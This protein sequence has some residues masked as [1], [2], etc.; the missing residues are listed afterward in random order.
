MSARL[1]KSTKLINRFLYTRFPIIEEK[2]HD[3]DVDVDVEQR[4]DRLIDY[5]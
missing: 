4:T 3:G 2:T 5:D 1:K